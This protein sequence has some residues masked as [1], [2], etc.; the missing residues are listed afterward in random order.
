M[1][2]LTA[3][4]STQTKR[5]VFVTGG[6]RS[7]KSMFAQSFV[8][9]WDGPLL[10]VAT[11]QPLDHEM[12]SRVQKHKEDRGPR[13]ETLEEPLDLPAALKKAERFGGALIDCLTLWLS[14]LMCLSDLHEKLVSEAISKFLLALEDFSGSLCLVT[15]EVGSGIVPENAMARLFRDAAGKLNQDVAARA[16]EAYLIASGLPLRLK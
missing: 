14:N 2:D 9:K 11:A 15:N 10:Y 8:E 4:I 1:T 5:I 3:N 6:A 16:T 12:L 13:W 7:G